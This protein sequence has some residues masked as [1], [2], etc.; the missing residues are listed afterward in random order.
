[1]RPLIAG[2]AFNPPNEVQ[3]HWIR[4]LQ[5]AGGTASTK[6]LQFMNKTRIALENKGYIKWDGFEEGPRGGHYTIYRLTDFGEMWVE[7]YPEPGSCYRHG[8][9]QWISHGYAIYANLDKTIPLWWVQFMNNHYKPDD[10]EQARRDIDAY[11]QNRFDAPVHWNWLEGIREG[12][13]PTQED[14]IIAEMDEP[15]AAESVIY[16]GI[17]LPLAETP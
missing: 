4:V 16:P 14:L 15:R 17:R 6:E 1:M 13:K 10:I 11:L 8:V 2:K 12:Y 7:K 9:P 5:Q 3:E